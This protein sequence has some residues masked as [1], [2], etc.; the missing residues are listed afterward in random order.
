VSSGEV[1][2]LVTA[3]EWYSSINDPFNKAG[4]NTE[5]HIDAIYSNLSGQLELSDNCRLG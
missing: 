5:P 4:W 1:D 3:V 2:A